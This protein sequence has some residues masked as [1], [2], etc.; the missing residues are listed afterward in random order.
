MNTLIIGVGN[1][2]LGDDGV[3]IHAARELMKYQLPKH[4]TVIDGGTLG[5]EL[6]NY[7]IGYERL[8]IL[9]ALQVDAPP[10][11]I[12]RVNG[13]DIQPKGFVPASAHDST[14]TD[15]L[16]F[17]SSVISLE[18]V[19]IIGVVPE[20]TSY[21]SLSLSECVKNAFPLLIELIL[22]ELINDE[23]GVTS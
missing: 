7:Y 11:T 6:I 13:V 9:D 5:I 20:T 19:T 4:V 18:Q 10:G 2:L 21:A 16:Y 12:V 23:I 15:I 3:G 22:T 17:T 8:I 1:I 14:L